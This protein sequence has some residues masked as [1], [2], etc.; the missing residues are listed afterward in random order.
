MET[1]LEGYFKTLG[2]SK[3][4]G[5]GW[6]RLWRAEKRQQREDQLQEHEDPIQESNW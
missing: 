5:G 4:G 2:P 3:S 1:N 6:R